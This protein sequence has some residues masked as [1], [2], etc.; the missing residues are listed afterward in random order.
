M[1]YLLDT[2]VCV[3]YLRGRK[4]SV[5]QR[6]QSTPTQDVQLCSVVK[7]ELFLGAL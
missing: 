5:F 7:A 4:Q 1:T 2:N 6:L 3:Q